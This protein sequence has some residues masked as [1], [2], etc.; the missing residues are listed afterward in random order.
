MTIYGTSRRTSAIGNNS[1]P[2]VGELSAQS[3]ESLNVLGGVMASNG[4]KLGHEVLRHHH[5][6][7]AP[8]AP[9]QSRLGGSE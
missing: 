8:L 4:Q 3:A 1:S 6:S 9:E 7:L 2:I 5:L